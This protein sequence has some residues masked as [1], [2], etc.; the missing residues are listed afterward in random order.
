MLCSYF[1][2]VYCNTFYSIFTS[3]LPHECDG[4][5]ARYSVLFFT[6]RINVKDQSKKQLSWLDLGPEPVSDATAWRA[7]NNI[8]N[9]IEGP[10]QLL[11]FPCN[12]LQFSEIK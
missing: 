2:F 9:Y 7:R 11:R 8:F 3:P 10:I 5:L 1:F 6:A 4:S 12:F